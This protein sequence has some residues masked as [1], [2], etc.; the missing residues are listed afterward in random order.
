MPSPSTVAV[1]R[2]VNQVP[3]PQ[4]YDNGAGAYSTVFGKDGILYAAPLPDASGAFSYPT[5][6]SS[7]ALEQSGVLKNSGGVI[8]RLFYTSTTTSGGPLYIM[9]FNLTAVPTTGA[10]C[11]WR[12]PVAIGTATLAASGVFDFGIYGKFFNTG[13]C[14]AISS[15]PATYTSTS[16]TNNYLIE[17]S[18]A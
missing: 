10:A 17:A 2:D 14:Y 18:M 11:A 3:S 7:T 8:Y 12:Q 16:V 4:Y 9:L 15:T 1:V 13:I 5:V 6:Y